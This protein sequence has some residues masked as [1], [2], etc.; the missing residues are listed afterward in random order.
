MND[1]ASSAAAFTGNGLACIRGERVVFV[2]L[3]FALAPGAVLVLRGAN[4]SGKSSL[5]RLAAGLLPP[6]AGTLVRDGV[7]VDTAPE[8]HRASLVYVGHRDAVK[9]LLTA[10]ENARFHA[11]M[12][13][14]PPSAAP[15]ALA[16]LGIGALADS[17][18]RFLSSGQRRRLS[19]ARLAATRAAP[20]PPALWLLD[21]PTVGLDAEAIG[22]LAAL[23]RDHRAA[24]G[25]VMLA[26]HTDVP[27][28][29]P[30]VLQLEDFA[31]GPD[32]PWEAMTL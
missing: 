4:G 16:A 13:G 3:S 31:P 32:L 14:A 15:A 11:R 19:L 28:D 27:L 9:P 10:E 17:P 22:L 25:M 18:A 5:L 1:P 6:A 26:T 2:D 21:E 24:G 20:T 12:L 23:I 30:A 29:A 8:S 7:P